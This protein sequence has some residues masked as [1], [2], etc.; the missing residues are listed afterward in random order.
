MESQRF[1]IT[2][3]LSPRMAETPEGFLICYDVPINRTGKYV[4]KAKEVPIDP[5]PNG[6]VTIIREEDEVF[7][8]DAIKSFEGKPVTI[9]HPTDFVTPL[10]WTKLAHGMAQNVRRGKGEQSDLA[11]ADLLITTEDAIKLIRAGLRE[12]SCGYD[13]QYDQIE[14]GL[15]KQHTIIGNH[16]ALVV[17][18]RAG[19]RCAIMDKA[20]E[21][22][23]DCMCDKTKTSKE[24]NCDMKQNSTKMK[25]VLCR[26]FPKLKP[27]LDSVKDEDLELGEE[28]AG[29]VG[30]G[31]DLEAV[32]KMAE[33]AKNSAIQAVEAAKQASEI[34]AGLASAEPAAPAEPAIEQDAG[35]EGDPIA[36]MNSKLDTLIGM[37]QEFINALRPDAEETGV[38]GAEAEGAVEGA[39]EK[40]LDE[41]EEEGFLPPD[42]EDDIEEKIGEKTAD[43]AWLDTVS[44]ADIIS[45]GI[46][47][48][49][50]KATDLKKVCAAVKRRALS[51]GMTKD[52]AT[53]IKPLLRGKKIAALTEDALDAVFIAASEM[54]GRINNAKVQKPKMQMKDL[55]CHSEISKIQ[56]RNTEFWASKKR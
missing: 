8:D 55:S 1:Y 2:E 36:S 6:L 31:A 27:V 47:V 49:K 23:A 12:V 11:I 45:P 13:A 28:T 5:G 21:C 56:A 53:I 43:A 9:N 51:N 30:E 14:P 32:Q 16:I 44:R 22:C 19:G 3:Q 50:P 24:D 10:N 38:E 35:E 52:S 39:E 41:G 17:K 34:V 40:G 4:Y 25:D 29:A 18:G 7:S 48:A 42:K 54:V 26:I 37:M 33:E 46:V 20:C 15:G